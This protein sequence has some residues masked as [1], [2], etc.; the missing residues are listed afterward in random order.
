MHTKFW[1]ILVCSHNI[2]SPTYNCKTRSG[3]VLKHLK[4]SCLVHAF[5]VTGHWYSVYTC[6]SF[7]SF[8]LIMLIFL[9]GKIK[10]VNNRAIPFIISIIHWHCFVILVV[11]VFGVVVLCPFFASWFR[12]TTTI[13]EV[14][15]VLNDIFHRILFNIPIE[16]CGRL[17]L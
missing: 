11:L 10:L 8:E 1:W 4:T 13:L 15:V 16:W 12:R 17:W 6:S 7:L 14:L 3:K 9:G 5:C 2:Q